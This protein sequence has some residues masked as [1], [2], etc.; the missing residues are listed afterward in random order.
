MKLTDGITLLNDADVACYTD[1]SKLIRTNNDADN[2]SGAGYHIPGLSDGSKAL[3][4]HVTVFQAEGLA[5]SEAICC[6]VDSNVR[7]KRI[8]IYSDSQAAIRALGSCYTTSGIVEEC[9][10]AIYQLSSDNDVHLIWVRGH[11]GI[12]GNE[13]ADRLA[14]AAASSRPM[15]PSPVIGLS[16][17][18]IRSSVKAWVYAN[19]TIIWQEATVGHQTKQFLVAP[20]KNW[21]KYLV[22]LSRPRLRLT[23]QILTGH[24]ALRKHLSKL[25]LV[26]D[27]YCECCNSGEEETVSHFLLKCRKFHAVRRHVFGSGSLDN[28]ILDPRK[29]VRFLRK[30]KRFDL[31][32]TG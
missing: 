1:G 23:V 27:S 24:C 12:A 10:A 6:L 2:L 28:L 17:S 4:S 7:G 18:T 19:H 21:T 15:G 8:A 13:E 11:V 14:R 26:A 32:L 22:T 16:L 20:N 3:G 9:R 31:V 25:K 30:T 29:I 5:I